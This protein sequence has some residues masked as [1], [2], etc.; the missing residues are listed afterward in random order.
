MQLRAQPATIAHA[1]R[2][3]PKYLACESSSSCAKKNHFFYWKPT[4]TSLSSWLASGHVPEAGESGGLPGVAVGAGAVALLP[5]KA[6]GTPYPAAGMAVITEPNY[7][8]STKL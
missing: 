3:M 1:P 8:S 2:T 4:G 7:A 5:A 6:G